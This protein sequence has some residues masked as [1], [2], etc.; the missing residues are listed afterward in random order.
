M[1]G[2]NTPLYSVLRFPAVGAPIITKFP[3]GLISTAEPK[4]LPEPNRSKLVSNGSC[5]GA[6]IFCERLKLPLSVPLVNT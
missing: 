1:L 5:V 6:S 3:S 2:L 4:L